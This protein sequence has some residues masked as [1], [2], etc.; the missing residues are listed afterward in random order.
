MILNSEK[1]LFPFPHNQHYRNSNYLIYSIDVL[2][3]FL[4]TCNQEEVNFQKSQTQKC[5]YRYYFWQE[6]TLLL[7]SLSIIV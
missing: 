2:D 7:F 6:Y 1:N 4:T 5:Y 3:N